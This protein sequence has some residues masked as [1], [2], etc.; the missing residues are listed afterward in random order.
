LRSYLLINFPSPSQIQTVPFTTN[1]WATWQDVNEDYGIGIASEYDF[2]SFSILYPPP[3]LV[4]LFLFSQ[5]IT[6][7][8]S[9]NGDA[10][11]YFHYVRPIQNFAVTS[12]GV[13]RGL[14]YISFFP[15]F[16]SLSLSLP[17][18]PFS[19]S[20]TFLKYFLH[21]IFFFFFFF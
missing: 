20:L 9:V 16:P 4:F 5:G 17:L 2:Y 3:N 21:L 1:A 13:V 11:E 8:V 6:S 14:T 19:L 15:L 10:S 12:G 18:S 7:W